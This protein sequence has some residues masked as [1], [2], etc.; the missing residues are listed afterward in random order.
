MTCRA[1]LWP[2]FSLGSATAIDQ[3]EVRKDKMLV[4][5]LARTGRNK[6]PTYRIVAAES[7]RAVTGKFVAILG[8]YNPHTKELVIKKDQTLKY[9]SN[10]AQPS[11]SVVR[12]LQ[13]EK[14][15]L[16]AWVQLKTKNKAPKKEVAAEPEVAAAPTEAVE[17]VEA[18]EPAPDAEPTEAVAEQAA[19]NSD[20]IQDD[21]V[22]D[23]D[24][25]ND[26]TET[27]AT[28]AA[29]VEAAIEGEA[30]AADAA[31]EAAEEAKEA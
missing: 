16:P 4:I 21:A 23:T 6:Y 26:H 12:L 24:E 31:V 8:H 20:T 28:E 5:R 7:A 9:I 27:A 11:N 3:V 14:M 29:Q 19:A 2:A 18:S 22:K 1:M 17:T 15:E 25:D 10:G 13:R 30:A